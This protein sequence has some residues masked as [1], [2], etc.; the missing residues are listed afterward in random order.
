M[1]QQFLRQT[2]D[3]YYQLIILKFLPIH[4]IIKN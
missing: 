2:F 1:Y 4:T 3:I